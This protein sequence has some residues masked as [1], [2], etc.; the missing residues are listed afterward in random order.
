MTEVAFGRPGLTHLRMFTALAT[1]KR[2]TTSEIASSDI[3]ISSSR[4]IADTL[5]GPRS[6]GGEGEVEVVHKPRAPVRLH[7]FLIFHLGKD[8]RRQVCLHLTH[9]LRPPRSRAQYQS[10]KAMTLVSQMAPPLARSSLASFV[11]GETLI[12]TPRGGSWHRRRP[13]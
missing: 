9:V 3:I 7:V 1:T 11:N 4:P 10:P 8:Q 12:S 13:R 2:A 5:V 6:G